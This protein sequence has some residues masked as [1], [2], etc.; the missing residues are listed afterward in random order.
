MTISMIVRA[1][2]AVLT[3]AVVAACG[4][5]NDRGSATPG[6]S[7]SAA[8]DA[9]VDDANRT[10]DAASTSNDGEKTP[11]TQRIRIA[12]GADEVIV[13]MLDNATASDFLSQLPMT[14]QLEDYASA[15]KIAYLPRKLSTEGAPAGFDPSVGDL[16]Y[17]APWGN[18]AFFYKDQP[19]ASGLVPLGAIESG[20]ATL[21]AASGKVSVRI[22][23]VSGN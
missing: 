20:M 9:R 11:M 22:E 2:A 12:I 6:D 5:A 23:R 15:E 8:N 17:Y 3:C 18:L 10:P 21:A 1:A 14:V 16:T 19:Y 13:K 4:H 7:T